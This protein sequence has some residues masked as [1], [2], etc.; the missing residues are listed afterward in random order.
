M[1][2]N[3]KPFGRLGNRLFL[4]AHLI[5]FSKRYEVPILNLAFRDYSGLFPWLDGN[6]AF[7]YPW[8]ATGDPVEAARLASHYVRR[9]RLPW[10]HRWSHWGESNWDYDTNPPQRL[11]GPL[12]RGRDVYFSS[13][14]FRGFSSLVRCRDEVV[15]VFRPRSEV[16]NA[17]ADANSRWHSNASRLVGVHIR[18]EDYRGTEQFLTVAQYRSAMQRMLQL[19]QG[20]RVRF[21][22]F[23]NEPLDLEHFSGL[24]VVLSSGETPQ[25]DLYGMAQCDFLMAPPSTFSGWASYYGQ[26]PLLQLNSREEGWLLEDFKV[27]EG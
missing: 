14:L 8:S 25:F 7:A 16:A 1:L 11:L 18:W 23:S 10:S 6:A 4:A 20:E 19:S 13:W 22:I 24:P 3:L 12:L 17:V 9:S 2:V 26:V 5:A 21:V 15:Q 27:V